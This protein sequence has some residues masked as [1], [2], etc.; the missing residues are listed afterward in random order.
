MYAQVTANE[1]TA[2]VNRLPPAARRLDTQ[3]WVLGLPDA[4]VE[5]QQACGWF[6]VVDVPRPDDTPTTTHEQTVELVNAVP[7]V[8]WTPRPWTQ[9]ELDARQR[10]TNRT[11]I[12][13]AITAALADLDTLIAAPV[14]ATVPAG[15]MNTAAL[16][17]AM[18]S[19]RDAVQANRAGAQ[20]VATTLKQTIRLV[21]GDFDG[22]D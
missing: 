21:R 12:D 3:A 22:I 13:A 4:P 15:T 19:M 14:V 9:G 18:R 5:L 2:I 16:S 6:V 20:R 1:I 17:N 11:T 8:A 10:I 7:T